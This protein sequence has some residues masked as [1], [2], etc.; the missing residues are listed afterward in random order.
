VQM[1]KINF[2]L[3]ILIAQILTLIIIL[4]VV[5]VL[6]KTYAYFNPGHETLYVIPDKYIGWRMTPDLQYVSTGHN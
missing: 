3:K 5:E 2:A 1:K 6:G 4:I